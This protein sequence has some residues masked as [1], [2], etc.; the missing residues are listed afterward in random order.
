M[1]F[2]SANATRVHGITTATAARLG[3]DVARAL[4]AFSKDL[5]AAEVLVAH[6]VQFD[7]RVVGS[8]FYRA[9]RTKNPLAAKTFYCTMRSSTNFCRLPGGRG[10]YKWPTLQELHRAL[11]NVEFGSAHN[12]VVDV[13]ACAKCFFELKRRG[14]IS[15]S[16]APE[17]DD[18]RDSLDDQNLFDEI[19]SLAD[20]C[21]W[22]DTDRF[23]D[24][25]YSQFEDRGF[26][27]DAQRDA[28]IRI[29]DMLEEKAG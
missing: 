6:N 15:G 24:N 18:D 10:R 5:S 19:Y 12:A 3:I 13:R 17:D 2:R 4:T 26:I 27:T 23:V 21:P 28:L 20:R 29:R 14:V 25:V 7:E 8:E 9:G 22:F 16:E 11:F 1:L